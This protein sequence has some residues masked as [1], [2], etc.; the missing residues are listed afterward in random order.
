LGVALG[1]SFFGVKGFDGV[2]SSPF[3]AAS[4]ENS[5]DMAGDLLDD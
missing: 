1:L 3:R 4:R 2:F 5:S